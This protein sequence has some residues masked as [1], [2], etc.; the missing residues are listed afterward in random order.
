VTVP[1]K[2]IGKDKRG[3]IGNA[4]MSTGT[5]IGL[6]LGYAFVMLVPMVVYNVVLLH[7]MGALPTTDTGFA[8]IVG[9]NINDFNSVLE[10]LNSRFLT[11]TDRLSDSSVNEDTRIAV[12]ENA[13]QHVDE[14]LNVLRNHLEF[15]TSNLN[16]EVEGTN[17][18]D[19][20]N[21]L[22]EDATNLNTQSNIAHS[23]LTIEEVRA[24]FDQFSNLLY[25]YVR[26]FKLST[27]MGD[28]PSFD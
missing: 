11:V 12:L 13:S 19:M 4:V 25:E 22:I 3:I 10:M 5:T 1:A 20:Y 8:D 7:R 15:V 28:D 6:G 18:V 21:E 16:Q 23:N 2:N 9:V 14:T 24:S 27:G 26:M 17:L